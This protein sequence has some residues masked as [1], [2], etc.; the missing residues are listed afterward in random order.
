V[1]VALDL[2]ARSWGWRGE[3]GSMARGVV[4]CTGAGG[5]G[6]RRVVVEVVWRHRVARGRWLELWCVHVCGYGCPRTCAVI[7]LGRGRRLAGEKSPGRCLLTVEC[8]NRTGVVAREGSWRSREVDGQ[9]RRRRKGKSGSVCCTF[10]VGGSQILVGARRIQTERIL[11]AFGRRDVWRLGNGGFGVECTQE[12]SARARLLLRRALLP[13]ADHDGPLLQA[14]AAP[15]VKPL[16][17]MGAAP[18]APD[19]RR[20]PNLAHSLGTGQIDMPPP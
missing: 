6:R 19:P 10:G 5:H 14:L 17:D 1:A 2:G 13:C 15:L 11:G 12:A 20:W 18:K 4:A 16:A 8:A 9:Q 7:L 3:L